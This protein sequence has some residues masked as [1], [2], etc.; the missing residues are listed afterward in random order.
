MITVQPTETRFVDIHHESWD[1]NWAIQFPEGIHSDT[2]TA[3]TWEEIR[4]D[5]RQTGPNAWGYDWRTTDDYIQ[6]VESRPTENFAV[7][8]ALR[9]EIEAGD[10]EIRLKLVLTNESEQTL[11]GVECDGGCLQARSEAFAG[12]DEVARSRIMIGGAMVG[13]EGLDRSI[14]ERCTYNC[15]LAQYET[16][17]ARSYE[18]FWGRSKDTVDAP[19]IVGAVSRDAARAVALGYEC[20]RS[21][22][23]NA[24][25]HH[26]LHSRPTFGQIAPGQSITRRGYVLFGDDID[27]LARDLK[28]R[29]A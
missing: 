27:P 7:G 9:A 6:Q 1:L 13:M 11:E 15:D 14:P 23:Q 25:H 2:G 10:D 5:W 8:L 28:A 17:M 29:I 4:P 19:A 12:G 24:D 16:D 22:L 20:A 26:C 3:M 21:G 18:F